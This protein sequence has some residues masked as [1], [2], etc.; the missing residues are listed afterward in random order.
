VSGKRFIDT[1]VLAY[2]FDHHDQARRKSAKGVLRELAGSRSGVVST[3][4]M[5][6]LYSVLTRKLALEPL[7]ARRAVAGAAHYEVVT[8]TPGMVLE[9]IDCAALEH[10]SIWDALVIIAAATARCEEVLTEDLN[11]GQVIRGVRVVNPF[12]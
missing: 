8:L 3:Q 7:A 11:A 10:L 9:A 2:A 12:A 5:Q 1:N 6:E 4:V